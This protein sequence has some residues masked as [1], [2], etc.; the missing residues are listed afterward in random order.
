MPLPGDGGPIQRHL[1]FMTDGNTRTVYD[2]YDAYGL[3]FFNRYKTSYDPVCNGPTPTN[4]S[5]TTTDTLVNARLIKI[6]NQI[7]NMNIQLWVVSYGAGVTSDTQQRLQ[8]CATPDNL[9]FFSATS[10]TNLI[11]NFQSIASKIS[12]LRLTS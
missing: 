7:K 11:A 1:I 4:T 2:N 5:C 3:G 8:Q 6:C 12:Q 9:H 10:T